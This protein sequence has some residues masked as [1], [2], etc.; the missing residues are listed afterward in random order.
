MNTVTVTTQPLFALYYRSGTRRRRPPW[1]LHA[2]FPTEAEAWDRVKD[3]AR[4][5]SL[6]LIP[7]KGKGDMEIFR[8]D[9]I[10]S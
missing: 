7:V 9:E 5:Q 8:V 4:G 3:M 1:T 2:V 6:G 10:R